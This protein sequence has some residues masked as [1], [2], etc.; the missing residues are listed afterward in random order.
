MTEA[1]T[2]LIIG[3]AIILA[4][5]VLAELIWQP[6]NRRY[7]APAPRPH[8]GRHSRPAHPARATGAGQSPGVHHRRPDGPRS[9]N[10]RAHGHRPDRARDSGGRTRAAAGPHHVAHEAVG[11]HR[12]GGQPHEL[13]LFLPLGALAGEDGGRPAPSPHPAPRLP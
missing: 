11:L 12:L 2:E 5:I 8:G 1:V 13:A 6:Y 7:I 4:F 3:G 9:G 10:R